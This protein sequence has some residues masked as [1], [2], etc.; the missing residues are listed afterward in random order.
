MSPVR[1]P[2]YRDWLVDREGRAWTSPGSFLARRLAPLTGLIVT[3]VLARLLSQVACKEPPDTS[4]NVVRPHP[5]QET[6]GVLRSQP[7]RRSICEPA[8]CRVRWGRLVFLLLPFPLPAALQ[9]LTSLHR[10]LGAPSARKCAWAPVYSA[11]L[12]GSY[13]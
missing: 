9:L 10:R 7:I 5:T 3:Q 12:T 2:G 11:P 13:C 6:A 1:G 8:L 4:K